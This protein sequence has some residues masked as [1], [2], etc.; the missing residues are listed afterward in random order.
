MG[1]PLWIC[2]VPRVALVEGGSGE[3]RLPSPN[4]V[5]AAL[6]MVGMGSGPGVLGPEPSISMGCYHSEGSY[7]PV[8]DWIRSRLQEKP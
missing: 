5:L 4:G 3:C 8:E 1:V 7:L 6:T 2:I